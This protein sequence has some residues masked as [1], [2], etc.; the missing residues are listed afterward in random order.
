MD[1]IKSFLIKFSLFVTSLLGSLAALEGSLI[2]AGISLTEYREY[3]FKKLYLS[4]IKSS[5]KIIFLGDSVTYGGN[6][7]TEDNYP[8]QIAEIQK[9]SIRK[10]FNLENLGVCE[11]NSFQALEQ[12]KKL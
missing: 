10:H 4:S 12:V 11:T 2:L 3:N 6:V 1:M 9:R 5:K 8:S 7:K